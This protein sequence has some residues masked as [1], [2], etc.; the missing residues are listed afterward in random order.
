MSSVVLPEGLADATFHVFGRDA[1]Q[2]GRE[3]PLQDARREVYL[4]VPCIFDT[5]PR[6]WAAGAA[7]IWEDR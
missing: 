2:F 1:L 6:P 7:P 4:E 3:R 5:G